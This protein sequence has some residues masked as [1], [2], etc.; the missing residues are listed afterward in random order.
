MLMPR[1]HA[2][3]FLSTLL[4]AIP[5]L[6]WSQPQAAS[7]M[8]AVPPK[9]AHATELLAAG[10]D[11]H[12]LSGETLRLGAGANVDLRFTGLACGPAANFAHAPA[13]GGPRGSSCTEGSPFQPAASSIS[14]SGS[15]FSR[16]ENFRHGLLYC[17]VCC[18]CCPLLTELD[19]Q[20][21]GDCI[22]I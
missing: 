18:T 10:N 20:C 22:E 12:V 16:C 2:V 15:C 7:G 14:P 9:D 11:Q 19:C 17:V 8:E 21:A 5:S 4:A 13:M 6:A 1:R 3:L